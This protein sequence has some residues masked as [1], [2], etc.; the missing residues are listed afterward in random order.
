VDD[1]EGRGGFASSR[2]PIA[3]GDEKRG[4]SSPGLALSLFSF[5]IHFVILRLNCAAELRGYIVFK[6]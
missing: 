4:N 1:A 3:V 6:S 5:S 2:S